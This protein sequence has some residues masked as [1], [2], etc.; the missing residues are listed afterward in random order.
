MNYEN[1]FKHL[2]KSVPDY[3]KMA[4]SMFWF[5]NDKD[6]IKECGFFK[7]DVHRLFLELKN[8]S[9]EANE[10]YLDYVKIEEESITKRVL[11]K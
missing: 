5:Q 3:R 7:N 9:R 2:F 11:K 4:F 8:I 1:F 10:A 6:L